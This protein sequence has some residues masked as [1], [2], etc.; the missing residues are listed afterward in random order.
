MTNKRIQTTE[1]D[2]DGIKSSLKEFMRGQS[3]FSDFDFDGSGLSVL[4][5]VL[6]YNTHYNALYTNLAINEAFLDSATKRSSVVSKAKEL[7][8]VPRSARSATAIVDIT[9][10]N[11][12]INS[13]DFIDIPA[14]TPFQTAV[15]GRQYTFYNVDNYI[16][17]RQNNQYIF[18][19]VELK[20]GVKLQFKYDVTAT[21]SFVI[22]NPRVDLSTIKV[23]VQENPQ[24]ATFRTFV[25]SDTV[26]QVGPTS[27]VYFVKEVDGGL[28]E[29]EFGNGVIGSALEPGNVVIVDYIVCN[30]GVPNG[31]RTFT[32]N[33]EVSPNIQTF[34]VTQA[35]AF[36]G[37][38]AE[39]IADIKWNA[40]RTYAAQNR[41]VTLEDYRTAIYSLYPDAQSINVWGGEQNTP[42]TYGDV[43]ISV[44]PI[45]RETLT[46]EEK[47]FILNDILGARKVV[48][49]HPKFIDPSYINV[50]LDVSFY[51]NPKLTTRTGRDLAAIVKQEIQEYNRT[52]LNKFDS[53]LKYSS[54]LKIIDGADPSI[55]NS[56]STLKMRCEVLPQ[57]NQAVQYVIDIGNPIHRPQ[58]PE[59]SIISTG[60]NVLNVPQVVYIDDVPQ[61]N[62]DV[63]ILR[64]FYYVGGQKVFVRNVGTVVYSRGLIKINDVVIT[65]SPSTTVEFVVKPQSYDVASVRNQIVNIEESLLRVVP[66]IDSAPNQ[67]QF[68]SSR[69]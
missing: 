4:L 32:Y 29:L 22:P 66:I 6:A 45:D 55:V 19:S 17:Y 48:T 65:G 35:I 23:S 3:Q 28:Y 60:I 46:S 39:S 34:V 40:S 30:E 26:L 13:P 53:I 20:E 47:S 15:E 52:V 38:S 44:K 9:F 58:A 43:F 68:V 41:C 37:A 10:I 63:G 27:D 62:Q 67:Y 61:P 1:L 36:G 14:F 54:L 24:T 21:N 69:N 8:Y 56:I 25:R 18:T 7:G 59:E 11:N 16:A 5:D 51:Y 12:Q 42:P 57:Y 50:E 31:A 2:F 64:M 33:G 49:V